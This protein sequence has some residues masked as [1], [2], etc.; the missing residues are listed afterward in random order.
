ME[1]NICKHNVE[2][3]T[4]DMEIIVEALRDYV[5]KYSDSQDDEFRSGLYSNAIELYAFINEFKISKN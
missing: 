4:L 5:F 2:L 1:N 3:T